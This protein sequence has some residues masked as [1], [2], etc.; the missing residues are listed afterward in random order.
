VDNLGHKTRVTAEIVD[1][2]EEM[3]SVDDERQVELDDVDYRIRQL[4]NV[5]GV[6]LNENDVM[7]S[8]DLETELSNWSLTAASI[9]KSK[10]V[11]NAKKIEA[12]KEDSWRSGETETPSLNILRANQG[13][14]A[15]PRQGIF[16]T[17]EAAK[18]EAELALNNPSIKTP[19]IDVEE[20]VMIITWNNDAPEVRS[21]KRG[22]TVAEIRD[23]FAPNAKDGSEE[24]KHVNVNMTLVPPNTKLKDGDMIFLN[25]APVT[26]RG[27]GGVPRQR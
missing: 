3:E 19:S 23:I 12:E 13:K 4:Q 14:T 15:A 27:S 2:Q 17:E 26:S 18:F 25:E 7:Y 20:G 6:F 9:Q 24:T 1:Q 8:S 11:A 5:A 22:S 10:R 16:Q 21:V